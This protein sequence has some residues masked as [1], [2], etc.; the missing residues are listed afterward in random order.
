MAPSY[1]VVVTPADPQFDVVGKRILNK[2]REFGF[3]QVQ[4]CR[5]SKLYFIEGDLTTA[6]LQQISSAL[7]T[8]SVTETVGSPDPSDFHHT[9]DVGLLPGVTDTEG[10]N[11]LKACERLGFEGVTRASRGRRYHFKCVQ[12]LSSEQL[13][14]FAY[15]ALCNEVVEIFTVDEPLRAPFVDHL[16]K[17]PKPEVVPLRELTGEQLVELSKNLKLALDEAEMSALREHFRGLDREPT[18]CE[19]ETFA[20]TWSEHC[21]HKTFRA[22]IDYVEEGKK[23]E[24][25][26]LLPILRKTTE[27]MNL[28]WIVSAFVDNAG[29]VKFHPDWNLAGTVWGSQHRSGRGHPRYL[30]RECTAFL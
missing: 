26:G 23:R 2:V 10:E 28:D 14:A 16:E 3:T 20:Q 11:L 13:R 21:V 1:T 5:A 8:D 7:L 6:A 30:R 24:L 29:I 4:E 18:R 22:R 12:P 17:T 27:Q 9:I 25:D 15:Q 19:L